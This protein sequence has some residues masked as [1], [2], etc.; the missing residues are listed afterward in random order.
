MSY[1]DE[2]KSMR[3]LTKT[4]LEDLEF[5]AQLMG[6]R[7]VYLEKPLDW[8]HFVLYHLMPQLTYVG[9]YR[10]LNDVRMAMQ[11]HYKPAGV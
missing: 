5:D 6:F 7:V 3:K 2:R 8:N 9:H 10:T 1:L 11:E 4:E